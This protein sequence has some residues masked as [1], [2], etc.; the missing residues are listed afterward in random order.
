LAPSS[1]AVLDYFDA[2]DQW[3]CIGAI[4]DHSALTGGG[5]FYQLPL[6]SSS[7]AAMMI[8]GAIGPTSGTTAAATM[9]VMDAAGTQTQVLLFHDSIHHSMP[10]KDSIKKK[11]MLKFCPKNIEYN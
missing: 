1:A 5:I 10:S 4:G 3:P 11:Q 9:M 6:L 8:G 7:Q 2:V